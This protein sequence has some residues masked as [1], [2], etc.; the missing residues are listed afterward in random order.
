MKY[1]AFFALTLIFSIGYTQNNTKTP[2]DIIENFGKTHHI[3]NPDLTLDKDKI[4]KVVFDIYTDNGNDNEINP[5][6]NGVARFLNMHAKQGIPKEN[7]NVVVSLHGSAAKN[8]IDTTNNLNIPLLKALAEA[9]VKIYVCGQS[10]ISRKLDRTKLSK[11][12]K[13]SLSAMSVLVKHQSENYQYINF[14]WCHKV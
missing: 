6:I 2:Q 14:N 10:L 12:V 11:H 1:L 8:A 4:Y 13:V 3:E 9:D 7:I 5:L